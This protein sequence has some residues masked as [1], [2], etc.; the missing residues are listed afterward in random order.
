MKLTIFC[1]G[2]CTPVNPGG[3]ACCAF[4]AFEGDVS[5][6][7]GVNRPE[8]IYSQH[9]CIGRGDGM[10]NNI[11][12]Y[13]A[14]RAALRWVAK[15]RKDDEVQIFTDSQLVVYQSTGR[16]ECHAE[17]LKNYQ[18][19]CAFYLSKL[20]NATLGWIPRDQN[21]VADALTRIA[22]TEARAA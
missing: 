1:D 10:T 15:F 8:P 4:V 20:P 3:Y 2:S 21:D 22:Y 18:A 11:A 17:H 5:G 9:G 6:A 16:W 13:R 7:A 14:V 12:E 19:E